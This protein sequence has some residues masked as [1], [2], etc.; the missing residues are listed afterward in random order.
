MTSTFDVNF[1]KIRNIDA[2]PVTHR[3][4]SFLMLRDPLHLQ[5]ESILLP[6]Q[7]APLLAMC[8]GTMGV[9]ELSIALEVSYGIVFT[10]SEIEDIIGDVL[11]DINILRLLKI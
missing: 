11:E 8:D 5:E 10:T 2:T 9:G 6:M 1:P 7:L 4:Q 3:G